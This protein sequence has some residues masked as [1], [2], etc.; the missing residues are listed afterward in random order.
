MFIFY[1][2]MVIIAT[3]CYIQRRAC[4]CTNLHPLDPHSFPHSL[5]WA[6]PWASEWPAKSFKYLHLCGTLFCPWWVPLLLCRP[7][8]DTAS[9]TTDARRRTNHS[10]CFVELP[11][12]VFIVFFFFLSQAYWANFSSSNIWSTKEQEWQVLASFSRKEMSD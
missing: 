5:F 4:H 12:N 11:H 7:P 1:V 2:C 6:I 3:A 8:A 9:C 10:Q